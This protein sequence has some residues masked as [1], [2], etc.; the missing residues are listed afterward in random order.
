MLKR[1]QN[2]FIVLLT[3]VILA[4]SISYKN[5]SMENLQTLWGSSDK[6]IAQ[7]DDIVTMKKLW[8]RNKTIPTKLE[9]I[10]NS[11][12][13]KNIDRFKIDKSKAHIVLKGLNS[14]KLNN[15]V[16]KQIASVPMQITLI[17][18]I[19]NDDTYGLELKCKW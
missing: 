11:L 12:D 1:Y 8:K 3:I 13:N 17:S 2:E 6:L 4:L 15:I 18:I 19:R 16:G 14:T 5:S 10:K 7:M 9:K